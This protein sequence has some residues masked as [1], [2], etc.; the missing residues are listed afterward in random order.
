[1]RS[2]AHDAEPPAALADRIAAT[3]ARPQFHSC[4]DEIPALGGAY[5]LLLRL[6]RSLRPDLKAFANLRLMPG[7]YVYCG[8]AYGPG[9]M[10]ARLKRHLA[11]QKAPR[12]HVDHLSL[13]A[14]TRIAVP[15][16]GGSECTLFAALS[17][18]P[19]FSI[20]AP[21]FGSS[22]CRRCASHLLLFRTV[23]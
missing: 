9:G 22:D 21:G 1:M 10:R 15:V 8:S 12:W 5:L 11:P 13:A 19:D 18:A 3:V 16:P 7:W 23:S 20:P 14:S 2:G 4:A 17:S 6:Q